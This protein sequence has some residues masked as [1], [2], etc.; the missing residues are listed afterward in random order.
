MIVFFL[1]QWMKSGNVI[2]RPHKEMNS[3]VSS[4]DIQTKAIALKVGTALKTLPYEEFNASVLDCAKSID[5][6]NADR[7]KQQRAS[8]QTE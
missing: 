3:H 1:P 7:V 5:K 2:L 6:A 4:L 8:H